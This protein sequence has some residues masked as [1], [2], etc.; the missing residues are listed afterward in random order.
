MR[1]CITSIGV[2]GRIAKSALSDDVS[3]ICVDDVVAPDAGERA[4]QLAGRVTAVAMATVPRRHP[5]GEHDERL[6]V[7][8]G[9][10]RAYVQDVALGDAER[11]RQTCP[12]VVQ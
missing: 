10:G 2:D 11:A 8:A 6:L 9:E 5:A 12:V 3:E 4:R 7:G 1:R